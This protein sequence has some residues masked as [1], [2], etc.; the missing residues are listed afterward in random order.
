MPWVK[1][2]DDFYSHPKLMTVGLAATGLYARGLS[3]A[4]RYST[5]GYLP[6]M[7]VRGQLAG[8]KPDLIK[9]LVDAGLWRV[10]DGGWLIPNFLENNFSR[11]AADAHK[12]RV[13]KV[14]SEAGKRGAAVRHGGKQSGK[15]LADTV[16]NSQANGVADAGSVGQQTHGPVPGPEP[17]PKPGP[18]PDPFE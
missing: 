12:E 16:A 9:R 18:E 15:P 5:D 11:T 3:Y 17:E 6:E 8:E 10:V 7:W 2:D 14:R 13:R 1:L 4:G